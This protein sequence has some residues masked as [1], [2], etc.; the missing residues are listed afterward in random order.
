MWKKPR[1]CRPEEMIYPDRC[2]LKW[3]GM[4]LSDHN[5][6]MKLD[7]RLEACETPTR[8]HTEADY[9]TWDRLIRR[10]KNEGRYITLVAVRP[11]EPEIRLTGIVQT[12]RG[13]R[14]HL[15]TDN[16]LVILSRHE[17]DEVEG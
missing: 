16:G 12:V 17:I 2:M 15:L 6:R 9:E 5:E 4:L 13:G 3:Q 10:S 14:I 11:N 1:S 7:T 8:Y